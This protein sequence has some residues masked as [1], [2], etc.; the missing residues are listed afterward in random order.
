MVAER[1]ERLLNS[2]VLALRDDSKGTGME[3]GQ[4]IN[5]MRNEIKVLASAEEAAFRLW[6]SEQYTK[7]YT[8]INWEELP[9]I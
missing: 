2:L 6:L 9:N 3:V 4:I 8:K 5:N 7:R 1:L